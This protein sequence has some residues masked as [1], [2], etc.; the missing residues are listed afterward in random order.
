MVDI[1]PFKG[2][3][4]IPSNGSDLSSVIAPPY[5]VITDQERSD[6]ASKSPLNFV[7][8]TLPANYDSGRSDPDFYVAAASRWDSLKRNNTV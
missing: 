1:R 4:Y 5:D 2:F 7:H 3:S 6:L 8:M